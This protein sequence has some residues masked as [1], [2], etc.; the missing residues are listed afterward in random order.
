MAFTQPSHQSVSNHIFLVL[1]GG[2]AI[3]HWQNTRIAS[4]NGS[5]GWWWFYWTD[6]QEI[7]SVLKIIKMSHLSFSLQNW[8]KCA[9]NSPMSN[10]YPKFTFMFKIHIF[11]QNSLLRLKFTLLPS[12]LKFKFFSE[13]H[14]FFQNSLLCLNF[15]FLV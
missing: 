4:A 2:S 1:S 12:C 15:T 6:I 10:F 3:Q 11:V 9:K 5:G 8:S 13:I 14:I 7:H